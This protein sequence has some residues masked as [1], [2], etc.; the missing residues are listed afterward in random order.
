MKINHLQ[1]IRGV[2]RH[3]R[4]K[5]PATLANHCRLG[6][7]VTSVDRPF[8]TGGSSERIGTL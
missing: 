6:V 7:R 3:L 4:S 2:S 1:W 8:I 5:R